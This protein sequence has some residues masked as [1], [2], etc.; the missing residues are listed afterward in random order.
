MSN[1]MYY[2]DEDVTIILLNNFGDY[3]Q[4]LVSINQ[5]LSVII[6]NKPYTLWGKQTEINIDNTVLSQL[7]GT[8][9]FSADHQL[10]VTAENGKLYIEASNPK[11]QFPRVELYAESAAKFCIKEAQLKFEFVKDAQ[12]NTIKMITYNTR[13]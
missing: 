6:F 12:G 5:A 11:D 4:S 2:P 10:I 1:L 13:G 3:G 9:K 8:Y 7:A